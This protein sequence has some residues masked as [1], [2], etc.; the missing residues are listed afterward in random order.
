MV[1][2]ERNVFMKKIITGCFVLMFIL[3]LD[4]TPCYGAE[5]KSTQI[6]GYDQ[7]EGYVN[8]TSDQKTLYFEGENSNWEINLLVEN[9]VTESGVIEPRTTLTL[10]PKFSSV[11]WTTFAITTKSGWIKDSVWHIYKNAIE[12]V[13]DYPIPKASEQVVVSIKPEEGSLI[14]I[15]LLKEQVS[16]EMISCDDAMDIFVNEY[17]SIFKE[18]PPKEYTYEIEIWEGDWI[19]SFDDNDGIGG[20]TYLLIGGT[21]GETDGMKMDE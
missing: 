18:Y 5:K 11:T 6:L 12:V 3:M 20:K 17:Y 2:I 7:V 1:P 4:T 16:E 21:T 10:I 19:V 13:L 15:I 8:E 14:D 9:I